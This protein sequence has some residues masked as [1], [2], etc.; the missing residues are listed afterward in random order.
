MKRLEP[1][2]G[3]ALRPFVAALF[4]VSGGCASIEEEAPPVDA[5][6]QSPKVA[7][8]APPA[9]APPS[10]PAPDKPV[11]VA[12]PVAPEVVRPSE[13]ETLVGDFA[14]YRRA[15]PAEL[16]REQEAARQ[17]FNATRTDASRVRYAMVLAIPGTPGTDEARALELLDPLVKTPGASLH[18]LAVLLGAYIQEHRRLGAQVVGLQQNVQGLQHNVQGLQQKLDAITKLERSLTGRGEPGTPRRK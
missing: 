17:A 12:P 8:A 16:G 1:A 10:P 2:L 5:A 15:A 14:R 7:V 9:V 11:S 18:P 13:I 4:L 6:A 3:P